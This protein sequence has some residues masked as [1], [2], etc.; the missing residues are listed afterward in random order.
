MR[1]KV[2]PHVSRGFFLA[3]CVIAG[4]LC[5]LGAPVARAQTGSTGAV[6]GRVTDAATRQ[7]VPNVVMAIDGTRLG[8]NTDQ[9]GRYRIANV[10]AGPHTLSVRRIGYSPR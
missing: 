9:D 3:A 10:P 1:S 7:G 8:A 6:V 5:Q 4:A 2:H